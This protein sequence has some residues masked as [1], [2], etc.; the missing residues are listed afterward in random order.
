[1]GI[2][3][4]KDLKVSAQCLRAAKTANRV[5]G[6]IKKT[7]FTCEGELAITKL[8]TLLVRTHLE[9]CLQSGRS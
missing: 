9:H 1:M 7:I 3:I 6:K 5:L 4:A 2:I 8:Y